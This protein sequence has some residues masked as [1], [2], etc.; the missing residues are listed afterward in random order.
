M[1]P[2]PPQKI[3]TQNLASQQ[4]GYSPFGLITV[5]SH[6][7]C[8]K[9]PM[10]IINTHFDLKAW[11]YRIVTL[12]IVS[13]LSVSSACKTLWQSATLMRMGHR[14]FKSQRKITGVALH[15]PLIPLTSTY[16]IVYLQHIQREWAEK[17]VERGWKRMIVYLKASREQIWMAEEW[18]G[19]THLGFLISEDLYGHFGLFLWGHGE[20]PLRASVDNGQ[21]KSQMR[22]TQRQGDV[23]RPIMIADG[24]RTLSFSLSALPAQVALY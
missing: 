13:P 9:S 10:L 19:W 22:I 1:P 12:K 18:H 3:R 24:H 16:G 4:Y 11:L 7:M 2:S 21:G 15:H 5:W 6:K 8:C 23:N 17:G 14:S 20:T